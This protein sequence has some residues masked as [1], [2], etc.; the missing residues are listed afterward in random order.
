MKF[1][2]ANYVAAIISIFFSGKL[3]AEGFVEGIPVMVMKSDYGQLHLHYIK[4]DKP[5]TTSCSSGEGVVL[6]DSN[7]SAKAGVNFALTALAAGKR[8]R[9]YVQDN[10]CSKVTGS[11]TTFP[12][13]GYY[14]GILN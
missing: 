11:D 10:Q 14:P 5:V 13:C 12:I 7:E 8:F 2:Y 6:L 9:C 1:R 4:L 3:L